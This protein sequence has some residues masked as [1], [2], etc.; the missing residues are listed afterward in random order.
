MTEPASRTDITMS[1]TRSP[2]GI[3]RFCACGGLGA[4]TV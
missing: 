2:V 3:R 1:S 4:G